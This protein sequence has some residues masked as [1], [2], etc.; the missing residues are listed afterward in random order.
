MKTVNRV[1]SLSQNAGLT[2]LDRSRDAR[3]RLNQRL[4]S[5]VVLKRV[6]VPALR[7]LPPTPN[8]DLFKY[9]SAVNARS[10]YLEAIVSTALGVSAAGALALAFFSV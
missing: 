8:E 4:S 2:L 6:K 7:I 5:P 3:S 1:V 9:A 10:A